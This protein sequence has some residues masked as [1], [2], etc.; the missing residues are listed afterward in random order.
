[1]P[2]GQAFEKFELS[3]LYLAKE[4][5][6]WI[7]YIEGMEG[8]SKIICIIRLSLETR[9]SFIEYITHFCKRVTISSRQLAT[10]S[11]AV[12]WIDTKRTTDDKNLPHNWKL[13]IQFIVD[14]IHLCIHCTAAVSSYYFTSIRV[15]ILHWTKK[16]SGD[17]LCDSSLDI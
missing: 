16:K 7:K 17:Q 9:R 6:W 8:A 10:P 2:K 14:C 13:T 12:Y 15:H 1:M 4:W 3:H 11:H 5:V